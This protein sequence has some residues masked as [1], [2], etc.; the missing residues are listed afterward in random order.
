MLNRNVYFVQFADA[1]FEFRVIFFSFVKKCIILFQF[2]S[3][4]FKINRI[5]RK[6]LLIVSFIGKVYKPI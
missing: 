5:E 3:N 6:R 1:K 4:K 2:S